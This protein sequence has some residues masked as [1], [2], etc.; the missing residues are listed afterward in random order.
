MIGV[1]KLSTV[2]ALMVALLTAGCVTSRPYE[3]F[4][5]RKEDTGQPA[6]LNN[7]SDIV[8]CWTDKRLAKD[9]AAENEGAEKETEIG[10]TMCFDA[11]QTF[12]YRSDWFFEGTVILGQYSVAPSGT[13]ALKV[14]DKGWHTF[15]MKARISPSGS[16][17]GEYLDGDPLQQPFM[18]RRDTSNRIYLKLKEFYKDWMRNAGTPDL[19]KAG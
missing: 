3:N 7:K 5:S 18:L 13:L 8:G 17:V 11:D 10:I 14:Y 16:L 12:Y 6:L 2:F 9:P 15:H 19:N 4:E 1:R